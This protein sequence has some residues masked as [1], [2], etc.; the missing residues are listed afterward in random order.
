MADMIDKE[1]A[2]MLERMLLTVQDGTGTVGGVTALIYNEMSRRMALRS[3]DAGAVREA[4]IQECAR[5]CVR[6]ANKYSVGG[7]ESAACR[8]ALAYAEQSILDLGQINAATQIE[9]TQEQTHGADVPA[10]ER[11]PSSGRPAAV[12]APDVWELVDR[13]DVLLGETLAEYVLRHFTECC[14]AWSDVKNKDGTLDEAKC[15]YASAIEKRVRGGIKE[16]AALLAQPTE[17]EKP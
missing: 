11:R 2:L 8:G 1:L 14:G 15:Q 12:A 13:P 16:L 9:G 7:H 17:K 6:E 3:L 5:V 10:V 4:T